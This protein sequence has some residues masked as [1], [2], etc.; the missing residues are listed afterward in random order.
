MDMEFEEFVEMCK[1][2]YTK[3]LGGYNAVLDLFDKSI[4]VD[5]FISCFDLDMMANHFYER[6]HYAK[7]EN[8]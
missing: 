3:F 8:K 7:E 2:Q 4:N 6:G 1:K 5:T